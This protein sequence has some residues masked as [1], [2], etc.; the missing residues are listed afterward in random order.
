MANYI[1]TSY[2]RT[3][4]SPT[5]STVNASAL[6]LSALDLHIV[7]GSFASTFN[8]S[9]LYKQST[10]GLG[11]PMILGIHV[12]S[13]PTSAQVLVGLC[14]VSGSIMLFHGYT[15]RVSGTCIRKGFSAT[16]T[17]TYDKTHFLWAALIVSR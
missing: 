12:M 11:K 15:P 3:G 17:S 6:Q 14:K 1:R 4:N 8:R 7:Y 10:N 16:S 9:S 5:P 13:I 2:R